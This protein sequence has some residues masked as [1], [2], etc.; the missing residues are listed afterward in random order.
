MVDTIPIQQCLYSSGWL[1]NSLGEYTNSHRRPRWFLHLLTMNQFSPTKYTRYLPRLESEHSHRQSNLLSHHNIIDILAMSNL[2]VSSF[3]GVHC[4]FK[5][6]RR[7]HAVFFEIRSSLVETI[8]R[9]IKGAFQR[10]G[11]EFLSNVMTH[12]YMII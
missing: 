12:Q 7:I 8:G 9:R 3:V 10:E 5:Y 2:L 11:W 6:P 4:T 1:F